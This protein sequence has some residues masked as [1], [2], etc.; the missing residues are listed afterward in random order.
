MAIQ[1][2]TLNIEKITPVFS[3]LFQIAKGEACFLI[4]TLSLL[5]MRRVNIQSRGALSN[6]SLLTLPL[7][8][9]FFSIFLR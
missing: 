8:Q 1:R 7:L 6:R 3:M 5:V 4:A 9:S 2:R